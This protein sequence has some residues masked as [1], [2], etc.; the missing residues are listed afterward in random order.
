MFKTESSMIIELSIPGVPIPLKRHAG[1]GNRTYDPNVARKTAFAWKVK[2]LVSLD[3]TAFKAHKVFLEYHMPIPKS[4]SK[5][6]ALKLE[7]EPHTNR[8]D[9]SNLIKFTEDALEGILWDDDKQISEINAKKVYSKEPK[10]IIIL[11]PVD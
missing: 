3:L 9:L 7:M 8:P 6:G 1:C 4:Y 10:T 2:A 11:H 5:K